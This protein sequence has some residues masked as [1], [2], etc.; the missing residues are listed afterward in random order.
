MRNYVIYNKYMVFLGGFLIRYLTNRLFWK[1]LL[2]IYT[3]FSHEA[4]KLSELIL[5]VKIKENVHTN[6]LKWLG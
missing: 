2:P 3:G 6:A 1:K 5:L 4:E